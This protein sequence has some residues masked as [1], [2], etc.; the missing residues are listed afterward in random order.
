VS[1]FR[2]FLFPQPRVFSQLPLALQPNSCASGASSFPSISCRLLVSLCSLFRARLV[3][4]Q[5]LAASFC[6][7]PGG[8]GYLSA[9]SE[10]SA[11]LYP[12]PRGVR[13]PLPQF[14]SP[15]CPTLLRE[16][17][18]PFSRRSLC[19][20]STFRINTCKSVSKQTTLSSFRINTYEK[21]RGRGFVS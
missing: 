4:F 19:A 21:P 1:P 6:K 3:C 13:Y 16:L 8:V 7:M 12:E 14:L 17:T 10:P 2:P 9:T 20:L 18:Y 5:Q 15:R 11:S